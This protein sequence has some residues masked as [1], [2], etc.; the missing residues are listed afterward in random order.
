MSHGLD[1]S[2][3]LQQAQQMQAQ[4]MAAQ[5]Q[6]AET[7]V[8]GEA[9]AGRV[10]ITMTA[11]GDVVGVS[12]AAEVVDPDDV[13]MLQD[14]VHGALVDALTKGAEAQQAAMGP[15]GDLAGGGLGGL[16]GG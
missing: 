13:E 12:I 11:G 15:L 10:K 14:L 1:M 6:A 8:V 3:L 9:G 4:L 7:E 5:E 2:S 16:L